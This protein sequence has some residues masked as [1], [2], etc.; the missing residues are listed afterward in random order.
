MSAEKRAA[1]LYTQETPVGCQILRLL[2][3]SVLLGSLSLF[4]AVEKTPRQLLILGDSLTAGYGLSTPSKEAFPAQLQAILDEKKLPWRVIAAGLSGDTTA[5][6]LRRT[7]WVLR[8]KVDLFLVAL[9]G[10]D[11]LRGLPTKDTE[12]NL[13]AIL[14][15]V[16][17]K[18]PAARLYVAGMQMPPNLGPDYTEAY[19]KVFPEAARDSGAGLI[20]FLLEGVGGIPTL[21]QADGIHPT[22]EGHRKI[23]ELL[24]KILKPEF[25]TGPRKQ[26]S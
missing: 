4:S 2:F 24:W 15:K 26:D 12:A 18:Y 20:P 7:D 9:G 16:K 17:A 14:V 6:G 1:F 13:K 5:G 10:N 3:T 8:Q 25:E 11:G 22:A 21:N 19:Q 23:A